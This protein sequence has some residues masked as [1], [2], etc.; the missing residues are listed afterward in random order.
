MNEI[1]VGAEQKKKLLYRRNSKSQT[2]KPDEGERVGK[3]K[4]IRGNSS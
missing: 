4:P 3:S 1:R 2:T